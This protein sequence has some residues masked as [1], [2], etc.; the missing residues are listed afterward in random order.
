[1]DPQERLF[2]Q[3]ALGGDRGRGLHPR[4]PRT[5]RGRASTG[6]VGV[7]VGVMYEEYQLYGAQEQAARPAAGADGQ[8]RP[9][10]ANR[11]SYYST[12]TARAWRSTPC[13]RRR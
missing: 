1:M 13:A 7:F 4:E 12:S 6:S 2:L 5:C 11:V 9:R 3:C 10:I 8:L